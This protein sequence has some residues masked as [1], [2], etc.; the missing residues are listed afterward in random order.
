MITARST[1][2]PTTRS[3]ADRPS[4]T[5][6]PVAHPTAADAAFVDVF[7]RAFDR[8]A[9]ALAEQSAGIGVWSIDL[10][11]RSRPGHRAVLFR[12]MGLEPTDRA[13]SR[14]PRACAPASRRSR[15]GAR[16]LSRGARRRP[17]RLRDRVPDRATRRPATLGL[18]RGR[19]VRDETGKPIRYSGVDLDITDRKAAEAALAAAKEELERLNT[20]LE[21]RVRDRT[22]E[23]EAEARRRVEAEGQPPPGA[24]DGGRRQ[25]RRRHRPRLQ[26]PPPGGGS[27][28][29]ADR[30]PRNP[31]GAVPVPPGEDPQEVLRTSIASA[32]LAATRVSSC[33]GCSRSAGSRRS[34]PT[35]L[36][37]ERARR[38]GMA[39]MIARALG[40]TTRGGGR[41]WRRTPWF[42]LRG[43][44]TSSRA[45]L[46]NLD[47]ER[48][49]RHAARRP[50]R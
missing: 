31:A 6:G 42:D 19:V 27:G 7:G 35:A 49:R 11:L 17:G 3:M 32:Q 34:Q 30:H 14:R 13:D 26:Q 5:P 40:E 39:D 24:E 9:L 43:P 38:R 23:L 46:L 41:S 4:R 16:R 18:R 33:S 45:S 29:P 15:T 44:T 1:P 37:V 47:R 10:P 50:P 25:P 12:I 8:D 21:Q 2:N 28:P 36:D 22:A 48:A 20:M